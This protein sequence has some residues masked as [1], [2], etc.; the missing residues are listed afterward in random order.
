MCLLYYC[1]F[2]CLLLLIN[3]IHLIYFFKYKIKHHI[4]LFFTKKLNNNPYCIS[5][6]VI[7]LI[8][9]LLSIWMSIPVCS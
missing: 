9:F 7:H 8:I 6:G 1:Y 4:I 2:M 5:R 3:F